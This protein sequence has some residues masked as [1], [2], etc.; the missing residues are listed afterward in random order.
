MTF[1]ELQRGVFDDLQYQQQPKPG[2]Q[3]RVRRYLNEGLERTLRRPRLKSLRHGKLPLTTYAGQGFYGAPPALERIDYIIDTTTGRPLTFRTRDWYRQLNP[4]VGSSGTP[5]Y[6]IPEGISSVRRQPRMDVDSLTKVWARSEGSQDVTQRVHIRMTYNGPGNEHE[7]SEVLQ[8]TTP[9]I[10][11]S[12]PIGLAGPSEISTLYLDSTALNAVYITDHGGPVYWDN[13]LAWITAGSYY[14]RYLGI[15]LY[16]TPSSSILYEVE[17]QR[18]IP[19]MTQDGDTPPFPDDFHEM[20][21]CY[22][23]GRLYRK[24]GRLAQAQQEFAEYE[25]YCLD[26]TVAIEYPV[27]YKPVA[28]TR[29][30]RA[31]WS[32]LGPW[33]PADRGD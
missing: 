27:N 6:W 14:N 29:S 8:G 22:A 24:D 21:Q 10:I 9:V 30:T 25:R 15:R 12:P 13:Y 4:T 19:R 28:G 11:N 31:G 1:A 33:Y 3:D 26:L 18:V 16:P 7:F 5:T 20:L 17:G 2:V 32:H 23:R